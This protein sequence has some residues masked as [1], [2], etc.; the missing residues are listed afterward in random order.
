MDTKLLRSL[1]TV[2]ATLG[3]KDIRALPLSYR[4]PLIEKSIKIL[5]G[6]LVILTPIGAASWFLTLII[7][8]ESLRQLIFQA[9]HS[10]PTDAHMKRYK[11]LL[12]V[13]L[14]FFWPKMR[15][16]IFD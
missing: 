10:T 12:I 9:Y 2:S 6:R 5:N 3:E 13:R 1:L 14:C 4:H 16:D 11:T 15:Q 7:V 8:P